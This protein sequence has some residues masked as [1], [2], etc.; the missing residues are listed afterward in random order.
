MKMPLHKVFS[1]L[2]LLT[3]VILIYPTPFVNASPARSSIDLLVDENRSVT[4]HVNISTDVITASRGVFPAI[5]YCVLFVPLPFSLDIDAYDKIDPPSDVHIYRLVVTDHYSVLMLL[6]PNS[7]NELALKIHGLTKLVKIFKGKARIDLDF[8]YPDMSQLHYILVSLPVTMSEFDIVVALPHQ[9]DG[10]KLNVDTSDHFQEKQKGRTY[11]L[12]SVDLIKKK[13][14][15]AWI[16]FT[17]P[18]TSRAEV[19][20]V[21]AA[22]VFWA[23]TLTLNIFVP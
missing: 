12:P 10:S 9:P 18:Q 2:V 4:A 16:T 15:G 5:G 14:S 13:P 17:D 3:G 20:I 1:L 23:L 21:V 11:L 22:W 7:L 8:S 6:T 19:G